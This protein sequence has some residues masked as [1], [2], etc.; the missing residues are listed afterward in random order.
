MYRRLAG[1]AVVASAMA[2][3]AFGIPRVGGGRWWVLVMVIVMVM[4]M[5]IVIVIVIVIVVVMVIAS[6][7]ACA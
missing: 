6:V 3:I 2:T 7:C 4:G 5:G 1:P